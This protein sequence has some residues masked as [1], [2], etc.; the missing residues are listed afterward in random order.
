MRHALDK[1]GIYQ[2]AFLLLHLVHGAEESAEMNAEPRPERANSPIGGVRY[3]SRLQRHV[4]ELL[5]SVS[6]R[7]R[8][9]FDDEYPKHLA[10]L[11]KRREIGYFF[12]PTDPTEDMKEGEYLSVRDACNKVLHAGFVNLIRS[13]GERDASWTGL[14][15]LRGT[16]QQGK[17][18][19]V[20]LFVDTFASE[21]C[22]V[23]GELEAALNCGQEQQG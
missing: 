1:D 9:I 23:L 7:S 11:P 15:E 10:T 18:W 17:P 20:C 22:D 6:I 19:C 16:D 3:W 13:G 14:A 12:D 8:I 2:D 4:S 21:L 5:V